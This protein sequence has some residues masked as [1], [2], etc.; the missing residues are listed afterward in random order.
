[1]KE[2]TSMNKQQILKRK[3][4]LKKQAVK[5]IKSDIIGLN[6]QLALIYIKEHFE[7]QIGDGF[8]PVLSRKLDCLDYLLDN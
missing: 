1:M 6:Q 4:Q 7:K 2:K 3:I 8:D 5:V